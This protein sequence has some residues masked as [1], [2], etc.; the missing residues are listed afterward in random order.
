[1]RTDH[2]K[3][4]MPH[5]IWYYV[6]YYYK[7]TKQIMRLLTRSVLVNGNREFVKITLCLKKISGMVKWIREQKCKFLA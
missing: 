3:R 6:R 7:A 1:M 4:T 2:G 5:Y